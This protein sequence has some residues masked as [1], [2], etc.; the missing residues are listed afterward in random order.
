LFGGPALGDHEAI[1]AECARE[2]RMSGDW[3]VPKLAE[4]PFV[5]KPPLPYWL[6]AL[7][8]Y[9]LP[10][11]PGTGLPVSNVA[12]RLPSALS[13]FGVILLVWHLSSHM[14]GR[15]TGQV[16]AVVASASVFVMLF[17]PNATAEM[18]LS[19]CCV[20]A[21]VHFWHAVTSRTRSR[22]ALH[23][24]AYYI[25]LGAGML[26]KG[27]APM[28]LVAVPIAVW[29]YTYRPQRLIA[30]GGPNALR[31]A[32]ALFL[33]GLWRQTIR[34]F[35]RLWLIPGVL[36]FLATFVPWL[37]AVGDRL[38]VAWKI[39]NWQYLQRFQGDYED[40]KSRGPLYYVPI[41]LGLVAPW[42][43]WLI[44]GLAAP[45]LKQYRALRREL[46]FLGICSVVGVAAMSAME[47]KKPY[48]V[49]PAIP[50][51]TVLL[52]VPLERMLREAR[53]KARSVLITGAALVLLIVVGVIGWVVMQPDSTGPA[54]VVIGLFFAGGVALAAW[55]FARRRTSVAFGALAAAMAFSF[56]AAWHTAAA[57]LENVLRVERLDRVLDEAGVP[58][59]APVYFA[60]QRPDARLPFYFERRAMHLVTAATI[61]QYTVDRTDN[62]QL[63]QHLALKRADEL[64][65]AELP[66]YLILDREH[67]GMLTFLDDDLEAR[68]V[69]LG[70]IDI[71]N[72]PDDDDWIVLTN[73]APKRAPAQ[74]PL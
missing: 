12:A 28:A 29:W 52:A 68:I 22:Q 59:D 69:Q 70:A 46:Y 10:P 61:V 15:R 6:V 38:P 20:W 49:L 1:V 45:W 14:F 57:Q 24:M 5:R 63:I 74:P 54:E 17:A 7:S 58:D 71:D 47:F 2:M 32:F 31:L 65:A 44:S 50:L 67:L 13:A 23:M 37:M 42:T 8:S 33:R 27:P 48:Y 60:D 19:F 30:R 66:A 40:T 4:S 72:I 39:W 62:E 51:M 35:T 26:A 36:L 34:A 55:F 9:V 41:V 56:Q 25:A 16:T 43:L 11:E 73:V 18:L 53:P 3:L 64:L 21:F